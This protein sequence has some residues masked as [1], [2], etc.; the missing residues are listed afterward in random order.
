MAGQIAEIARDVRGDF[1]T[2]DPATA[3]ILLVEAL[4][5]ILTTF[6]QSLSA[7][8]LR[9]LESLG[10]TGRLGESV[11]GVDAD[12]VTVRRADDSDRAHPDA[13]RHLGRRA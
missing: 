10:V 9:S 4:D 7:K 3:R 6:P 13:D 8:A 5:R 11:I 1:R 2:I 12:S